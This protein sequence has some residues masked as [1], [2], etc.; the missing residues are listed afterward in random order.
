MVFARR[1]TSRK[2]SMER[3]PQSKPYPA[4]RRTE[5][6]SNGTLQSQ[7]TLGR[8][9][10]TQVSKYHTTCARSWCATECV[11]H[12][13]GCLCLSQLLRAL[14]TNVYRLIDDLINGSL[15]QGK[16]NQ[17]MT[18]TGWQQLNVHSETRTK[19]DSYHPSIRN[20]WLSGR[21]ANLHRTQ[22][23]VNT[24]TFAA[25]QQADKP[26]STVENPWYLNQYQC[27]SNWL[28]HI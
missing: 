8:E 7:R 19:R 18:Q 2:S 1:T 26:L 28:L 27:T 12:S 11:L 17:Y 24:V 22:S 5:K 16:Q 14:T 23:Y 20:S 10:S 13:S 25:H 3:G 6:T 21:T 4:G 15:L 9:S